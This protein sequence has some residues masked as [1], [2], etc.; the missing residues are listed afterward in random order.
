LW[1]IASV[2]SSLVVVYF[3]YWVSGPRYF[4]EALY[5]LTILCAA[6]VAWLAGWM[7]VQRTD[8]T[9]GIPARVRQGIVLGGLVALLIFGSLLYTPGRLYEIKGR[10]GFS[11]DDLEPLLTS[12]AQERTPAL[13]IVHAAVWHDY[14]V[15]L[16]LQDPRLT[17][18]FIFVWSLQDEDLTLAFASYVADR[19]IYHYYPDEPG[20]FYDSPRP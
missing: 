18:P 12:E 15:Y 7:P 9:P 11:R 10:Y 8:M 4:F 6:G 13:L 16:H 14:G 2:Y 1:L 5:S 19:T 20:V 17:T 3:P